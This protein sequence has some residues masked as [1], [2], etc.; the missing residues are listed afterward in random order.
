MPLSIHEPEY[1]AR[2]E[3]REKPYYVRL[4]DGLHLGY[5]KGKLLSRW[6]LRERRNGRYRTRTISGVEPDD[7]LV[8]D[9][10]RILSFQQVLGRVMADTNSKVR[11]SF[12]GRGSADVEK[13]IAGPGVFICDKCIALS[14]LY[15]EHSREGQKL[16]IEDGEPVMKRGK[17]VFVPLTDE[18]Q[19]LQQELRQS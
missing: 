17:P 7:T 13:L 11:C 15:V 5:R 16:L 10:L 8:A 1:R 9:G 3:V 19:R 6:V 2:L 4:T 18:E 12:C 14:Q